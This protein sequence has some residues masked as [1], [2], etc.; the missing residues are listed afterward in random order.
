[1][2]SNLLAH[3]LRVL[4]GGADRR[5]LARARPG[6]DAEGLRARAPRRAVLADAGTTLGAA[7]DSGESHHR[8]GRGSLDPFGSG[9]ASRRGVEWAPRP[10]PRFHGVAPDAP[11]RFRRRSGAIFVDATVRT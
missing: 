1:M 11:F 2:A 6:D 4:E 5:R 9:V 7:F 8:F 10:V 3:H